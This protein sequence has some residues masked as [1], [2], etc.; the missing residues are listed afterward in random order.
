MILHVIQETISVRIRNSVYSAQLVSTVSEVLLAETVQLDISVIQALHHLLQIIF[1]LRII[2][3]CMVLACQLLA[4]Q[5]HSDQL[6]EVFKVQIAQHVRRDRY[7]R[8]TKFLKIARK[9]S[10]VLLRLEKR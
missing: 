7:V 3:A 5:V 2:S 10:T 4:D 9:D 6:K 1:V 8:E